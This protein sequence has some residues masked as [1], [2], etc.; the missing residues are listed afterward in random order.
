[1]EK[2]NELRSKLKKYNL[3]G[4][5]IPKNDE[6]FSEY[7]PFYKDDLQYISNFSGSYGLALI[8][9]KKNFLFVDGRYTVQANLQSGNKF[10]V[11]TLPL[12]KNGINLRLSNKRIG[13]DPK[14]FNEQSINQL[15]KKLG[16]NSISV[17]N[18]LVQLIKKKTNKIKK[19][20]RF[21]VL[22]K[23][24][25]GESSLEKI[26][27]LKLYFKKNSINI[28]L[29]TSSENVAWLLN[30]RGNDSN[31]SPIPNSFLIIDKK[32]RIFLFCDLK[33]IDDKFKKKLSFVSI[34]EINKIENF[35]KRINNKSFLIDG[36]TCSIFYRNII[37]K[38]NKIIKD[39]DPIYFLKSRKN[40][41]EINN[42]KKIHE[43]DGAALTK[44]LFWI[45]NNFNKKKITELSAQKKLLN[46]R[47]KYKKFKSLSFPTISS[48]GPNAA[49]I[50]Y[51]VS[52]K[53]NRVLKNKDIY[54]VD[55]GGQYHFGTTDVT[56]TI[57]LNT[58]DKK[59]KKIFTRVLQGHLNLSNSRLTK[60]TTGS[61]LDKVARK[62]LKKM[63]LDYAHGTGHG[64]GYFLNVH[65]GPQSISKLNK[66]KLKPGMILSN[67]PG[68][69]EKGKYG[70]RIENL[71]YIKKNKNEMKFE[72]LT[73]A[74][75]DKNLIE[76]KLLNEKEI[77]WLNN[78]H[79]LV[80]KKLKKYMNKNELIL[81]KTRVQIFSN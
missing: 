42:T 7:T 51:N 79:Q 22:N 23:S 15:S 18:N 17:N 57:S 45:Q 70:I 53:T 39:S 66:I 34:L 77:L 35:L 32:M 25:T 67:E 5:L 48:T 6:F 40:K 16:I 26:R 31:F 8:L 64:V 61:D 65:E 76:K 50:H 19:R 13:F 75:I 30:I 78:Y 60:N 29:V 63:N 47:K 37:K 81:L 41:V 58:K 49:I 68:Y 12:I 71:I 43:Y 54:L 1:M 62:K 55:S 56:R 46:F 73:Y 44:F 80:F 33:K 28:M 74:P 52:K 27:K 14:L 36:L 3:D 2:I 59:I 21:F 4:Y 11:I 69:Y 10:K 9:K 72:N 20:N 24:I 38:N